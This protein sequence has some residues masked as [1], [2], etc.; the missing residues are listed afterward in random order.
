ME[1]KRNREK[2]LGVTAVV[3]LLVAMTGS[4]FVGSYRI[5]MAYNYPFYVILSVLLVWIGWRSEENVKEKNTTLFQSLGELCFAVYLVHPVFLNLIYKLFRIS[6][7]DFPIWISLPGI[8]LAVAGLSL[9][10]ARILCKI[11]LL[12]R[13]VL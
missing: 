11:P 3:C 10:T 12:K 8:Y 6:L 9:L 7:L 5:L 2:R 1:E 4:R 13:Y